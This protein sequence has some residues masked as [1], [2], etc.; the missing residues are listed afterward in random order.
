MSRKGQIE[1]LANCGQ[2]G[3]VNTAVNVAQELRLLWVGLLP[4]SAA[5]VNEVDA[6]VPL[7]CQTRV[8][9]VHRCVWV[10]PVARSVG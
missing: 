1:D 6:F 10:P 2:I 3:R 4:R 5:L 9:F 7:M 8:G